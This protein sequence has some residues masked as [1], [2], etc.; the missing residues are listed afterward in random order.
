M[1]AVELLAAIEPT[2]LKNNGVAI[3]AEL[4]SMNFRLP[5]FELVSVII[6]PPYMDFSRQT[7]IRAALASFLLPCNPKFVSIHPF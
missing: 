2:V 3:A 1:V 6:T 7:V 5:K 4:T